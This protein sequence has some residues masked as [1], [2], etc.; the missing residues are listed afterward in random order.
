MIGLHRRVA[1]TGLGVISALGHDYP[2]FWRALLAGQSGIRKIESIDISNFRFQNGAEVRGLDLPAAVGPKSYDAMDRFTALALLAARESVAEA[3]VAWTP[4]LAQRAA[5]IT[6]TAGAGCLS[7]DHCYGEMYQRGSPRVHPMSIPRIMASASASWI[8]IELG[9]TGPGFTVASACSSAAHSIG[10]ACWLIRHGYAD[11][12]IAGGSEAPFSYGHLK[13]WEALRVVA[14][15]TC[16]PFSRHRRGMILGE[17]AAML[18]LEPLERALDRGATVLAELAG[19]GMSSDAGQLLHPLAQ[20]AAGA[21]SAALA[22]AQVVPGQIQLI[23][24][25]GTGTPV[26]DRVEAEAIQE[27]FGSHARHLLVTST[28]S[29]H[30]HALGAAG[31]LEAVATV[32]SLRHGLVPP[33]LNF[34]EADPECPVPVAA[35]EARA[36]PLQAAISNSFAFGGLN[37]SLVFRRWPRES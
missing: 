8:S 24:A 16:R 14:P 11:L 2:S 7:Q 3:R 23:N 1:V 26:N 29:A 21:M 5:V 6:G 31:A 37:V 27:V 10:L 15:D 19:V 4:A 25:H 22:D 12:A 18:V 34:L 36:L 32:L 13:A 33:T 20:G 30:G 28:K 9:L 17:G 35:N